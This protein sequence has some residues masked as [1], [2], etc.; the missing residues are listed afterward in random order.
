MAKVNDYVT[1]RILTTARLALYSLKLTRIPIIGP[2][3]KER[4]QRRI[5]GFEP[6]LA[7]MNTAAELVQQ[8]EKC[9]VGERVCRAIHKNSEVTEAVFLDELAGGMVKAGKARYATKEEA[10]NTLYR[11]KKRNPIIVSKVSGRYMEIYRSS[12]EVCVYWNAERCGLKCLD[13]APAQ[14]ARDI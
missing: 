3:V 1:G 7:D 2:R 13:K 14:G 8:S 12:P 11:Y 4:L 9:A 6:K 5:G 10:I